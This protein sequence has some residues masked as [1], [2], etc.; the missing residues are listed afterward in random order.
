MTKVYAVVGAGPVG[1]A[2]AAMLAERGDRVR[3]MSRSGTGPDVEGAE[4][5]GLDASDAGALSR[6]AEGAAAVLNCANPSDYAR[7]AAVWP[8]LAESLLT[9]AEQTGATLVTAASLYAYG[10]VGAPM[11]EGQA[12]T[13]TDALGS[14]RRGMWEEALRRHRAGRLHAVEVRASDYAGAG[15]GANGHLTRHV[16]TASRGKSA[17]VGGDP[18]LPHTW[19]DVADLARTLVAVAD[20]PASWGQVWHAPS[21]PPRSIRA[22]LTE[23]L[24]AVGR[25]AVPVRRIPAWSLA[26]TGA[27][28]PSMKLLG[29]MGYIF[30]H[31]YVMDS[32]RTQAKLGLTPTPWA[33]TCLHTAQG[34]SGRR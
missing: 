16:P 3:L 26:A 14:I 1:R 7:W 18:D 19:T 27:V 22:A 10:P 20:R 2:T 21:A 29:S 15:V 23:V 8:P 24:A 31:P 11:V 32:A 17:W 5:L 6:A 4:R 30:A 25:P 12:D 13:A 9:A 33:E 34:N 28:S